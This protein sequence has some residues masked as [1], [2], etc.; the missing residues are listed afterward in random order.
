MPTRGRL[1]KAPN[2]PGEREL[3]RGSAALLS[4][5]WLLVPGGSRGHPRRCSG[6]VQGLGGRGGIGGGANAA[7][8]VGEG[9]WKQ[10]VPKNRDP[11]ASRVMNISRCG[12]WNLHSLCTPRPARRISPDSNMNCMPRTECSAHQGPCYRGTKNTWKIC[13]SS[14]SPASPTCWA[15]TQSSL[16]TEYTVQEVPAPYVVGSLTYLRRGEGADTY[17]Y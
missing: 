2:K 4:R 9:P 16:P 17:E 6:C 10:R 14:H 11:L 7:G 8:V 1:V 12:L 3:P 13:F 5:C 15:G